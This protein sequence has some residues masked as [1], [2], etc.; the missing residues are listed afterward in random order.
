MYSNIQETTVFQMSVLLSWKKAFWMLNCQVLIKYVNFHIII[1]KKYV[2][3]KHDRHDHIKQTPIKLRKI[4]YSF[5]YLLKLFYKASVIYVIKNNLTPSID[6]GSTNGEQR[7][8]MWAK[9]MFKKLLNQP[10]ENIF[11]FLSYTYNY[12]LH[13]VYCFIC[14]KRITICLILILV[15][16]IW[17]PYN[18]TIIKY[19]FIFSWLLL[20]DNSVNN[21]FLVHDNQIVFHVTKVTHK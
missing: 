13:F 21:S 15:F 9:D 5:K 20:L 4:I 10:N 7:N 6:H 2:N 3:N 14:E 16:H 11:F 18:I 1:Y 17:P 8:C 19:L 12:K